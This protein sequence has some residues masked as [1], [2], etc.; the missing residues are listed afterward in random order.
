MLEPRAR[1]LASARRGRQQ[2]CPRCGVP[3][4]LSQDTDGTS[5]SYDIMAWSRLCASAGEG[6][7][8]LCPSAR[9]GLWACLSAG[10][11]GTELP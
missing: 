2:M 8:L 4:T 1:S 6:S 10:D 7:P 11:A 5:V 9:G 3:L